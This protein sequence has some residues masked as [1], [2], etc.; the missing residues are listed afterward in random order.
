MCHS[1]TRCWVTMVAPALCALMAS[2]CAYLRVPRIDPTG[3][4]VFV[5]PPIAST[6]QYRR[7]PGAACPWDDVEVTLA[8]QATVAPVGSEVVL[9]AGVCGADRILR[10]NRRLEWSLAPGGVGHFV[11]VGKKRL[12]DVLVGDFNCPG[13]IDNTLAIGTT[14]REYVRL[15]RGTPTEADDVCVLRGQ[16]WITL[17]SPLEGTSYVTVFCPEVRAWDSHM[18]S[19]TVHWVDAQW[20]L[21]PPAIV[22]AGTAR[23]LTTTVVR[24]S[25]RL[26][27]CGWLVRYEIVGG[28]AAG[29]GPDLAQAIEVPTD[30]AGQANVEM[31]Q[32]QP[33]PGTNQIAIQIVRPASPGIFGGRQLAVA[34]GTALTTWTAPALA[35]Q[36]TAPAVAEVGA[37]VTYRI[38]VSNPG[39]QP[40]EQVVLTDELPEGLDYLDSNPPAEINARTLSWQLGQLGAGACR[41]IELNCRVT[42]PGPV[43]NTATATAAGDLQASHEATTT[44]SG[45]R[46]DVTLS[47]PTQ[48]AVGSEVSFRA[49]VT[50]RAQVTLQRLLIID[51]FDP[52]LE[53]AEA[54][55]PIEREL[56]DLAPGQSMEI[57]VTFRVTKAGQ[58][59]QTVEVTSAGEVLGSARACILAVEGDAVKTVSPQATV[60]EAAVASIAVSKRVKGVAPSPPGGLTIRTVGDTVLFGI[61][62]TNTATQTLTNLQVEDHCD[63]S[64]VPMKATNGFQRDAGHLV[65]TIGSLAP[66]KTEE[67]E[68]LCRCASPAQRASNRVVVTTTDGIREEDE[69]TVEIQAATG[70]PAVPTSPGAAADDLTMT[71]S[72]LSDP[73][74]TGTSL[75]YEILV[76]NRGRTTHRQVA[77]VATVPAGM[78][79]ERLGTTGP[80][81]TPWDREGQVVR[82]APVAEIAPGQSV[83]YRI[84]VL[85]KTAGTA[86]FQAKLTAETAV[87]PIARS[88]TTEVF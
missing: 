42:R 83:T 53:H 56:G 34:S 1:R 77:V 17:T 29:F 45:P 76:T 4:R 57:D 26:A 55:S 81:Q 32:Q 41:S 9:T 19:A 48:A 74:P 24:R 70:A 5:E 38:E 10:T 65:Y 61:A 80:G 75:S 51:R 73:V 63:A 12:V 62:I 64:L 28:P 16:G 7:Q 31:S 71:V 8:P 27:C 30:A 11:A 69:A 23:V 67:L 49:V 15:D 59:S 22:P 25:D 52:G 50:N 47:G 58:F 13:K 20:S 84:R 72:D 39:D 78:V 44:S 2:G 82:F 60:P 6:P 3:E 33:A 85:A 88:E 66:G 37:T 87:Q 18:Q 14:S 68:V 21:P 86:T 54:V 40:A 35:V 46:V 43:T 79:L 36:M